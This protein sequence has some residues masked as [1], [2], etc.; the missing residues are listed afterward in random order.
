MK[1]KSIAISAGILMLIGIQSAVGGE[2]PT[3]T[4]SQIFQSALP[5]VG[6]RGIIFQENMQAMDSI[7]YIRYSHVPNFGANGSIDPKNFWDWKLCSSWDD[8]TCALKAG[9]TIEGRIYLGFCQDNS[10]L[11]CVEGLSIKGAENTS[12][13]LKYVGPALESIIDIPESKIY[14]IP[15]SSTPSIFQDEKSNLYLVR[16]GIFYSLDSRGSSN[17]KLDVDVHPVKKFIDASVKSPEP[18][19]VKDPNS[20]LGVAT[21]LN[22]RS[23]CLAISTGICYKQSATDLNQEYSLTI[24]IPAK[25]GGWF[26][27]RLDSPVITVRRLNASSNLVSVTAKPV[28][29][30][31][32]AGWVKYEDLPRDFIKNLYPSGGY[33][34]SKSQTLG[35][36]ADASQGVRGFEEFIAWAPYLKDKALMTLDTWSFGTNMGTARNNCLSKSDS[37]AGVVSTNA[38]VYA[39]EPPV[40]NAESMTLDY[41]VASPHLD[42]NGEPNSGRYT[43]AVSDDVIK[44]L[45][46][47][48]KL[49]ASATISIVYGDSVKS[50]GTVSV[51]SRDGWS[52]FSANGF[53]YSTPTIRVKFEAPAATPAQPSVSSSSK[54]IWCAKGNA[55]KK[56]MAVNPVCPKG[57][58]KIKAPL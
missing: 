49:P 10:E 20:G 19:V 55:K 7:G 52:Y 35:L 27:G 53:H 22:V 38:S 13:P 24:R 25:V 48:G 9:F 39:S 29:M 50:V 47:F 23:D 15:R 12:I 40:W 54:T 14:Q 36:Y 57:Y 41:K 21:V 5:E 34:E 3:Q 33:P 8:S 18:T 32:M 30:P 6:A 17:P 46:G 44:C 42:E 31:I 16:A 2:A 56:V 11:G 45:Y 37:V 1:K 43:L 51:G 4:P 26:R 28:A 58:K